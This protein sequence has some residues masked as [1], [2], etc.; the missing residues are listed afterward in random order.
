MTKRSST[1]IDSMTGWFTG[2]SLARKQAV[3]AWTFLAVPIV[4]YVVVRFWPALD[5]FSLSLMR[6]NLVGSRQ[7]VG[8]D[9]YDRLVHDPVFWQVMGN[10]FEYLLLGLRVSLV[11]SFVIA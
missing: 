10:T 11:L 7:F 3:W 8:F 1:A 4:F 9:N 2:L 6:W 5:A